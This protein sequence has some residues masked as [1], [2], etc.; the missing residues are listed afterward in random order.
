M[1]GDPLGTKLLE[2]HIFLAQKSLEV[3]SLQPQVELNI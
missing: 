1:W 3:N 2:I